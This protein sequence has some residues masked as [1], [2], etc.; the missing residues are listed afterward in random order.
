MHSREHQP[1]RYAPASPI[2]VDTQ[3]QDVHFA[4]PCFFPPRP[5]FEVDDGGVDGGGEECYGCRGGGGGGGEGEEAEMG[6]V[7]ET[8]A[9][10]RGWVGISQNRRLYKY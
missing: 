6:A 10:V 8:L 7:E 1:P 9:E 4:L 5:D 3:S 2:G